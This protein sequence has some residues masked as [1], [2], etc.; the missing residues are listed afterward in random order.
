MGNSNS[1]KTFTSGTVFA[2]DIKYTKSN[3]DEEYHHFYE[4]K[5]KKE[6][7]EL[8]PTQKYLLFQRPRHSKTDTTTYVATGVTINNIRSIDASTRS[9]ELR[10]IITCEW[11]LDCDYFDADKKTIGLFSWPNCNVWANKMFMK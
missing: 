5:D 8:P 4:R 7:L 10:C 1:R 3:T 6:L 9:V 2:G 11:R